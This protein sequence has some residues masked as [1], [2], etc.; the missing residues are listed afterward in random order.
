MYLLFLTLIYVDLLLTTAGV[1]L[2][3]DDW[4]D[5]ELQLN[6]HHNRS[7]L[8]LDTMEALDL[9]DMT[10]PDMDVTDTGDIEI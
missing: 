1:A 4:A 5:L 10:E 3:D 2:R 8:R 9:T 7:I 6:E